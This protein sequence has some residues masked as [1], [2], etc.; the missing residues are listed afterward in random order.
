MALASERAAK[1]EAQENLGLAGRAV[2]D[3]FTRISENALLKRQDAAEVRD[4]R[5]LRMQLLEVALDYYNRLATRRSPDPALRRNRR[6]RI[7]A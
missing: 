1:A 5:S 7:R 6:P 2:D 3:Y 4:L